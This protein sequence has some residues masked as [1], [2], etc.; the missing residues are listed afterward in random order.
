MSTKERQ[1]NFRKDL[2]Q[3]T[4]KRFSV[5]LGPEAVA[6]LEVIHQNLKSREQPHTKRAAI[7]AAL[8]ALAAMWRK[9]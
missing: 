9:T 6:A 5:T 3:S 4:G 8:Y 1:A 7:E 2:K